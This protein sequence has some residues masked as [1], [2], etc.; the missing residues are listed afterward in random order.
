MLKRKKVLAIGN[1]EQ[2]ERVE[3]IDPAYCIQ[4]RISKEME[5]AILHR[6]GK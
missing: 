6:G 3:K 4:K 1:K 2:K 5:Y